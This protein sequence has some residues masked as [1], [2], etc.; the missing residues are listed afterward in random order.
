M[1][2]YAYKYNDI[3][4]DYLVQAEPV[5]GNAA[6][7]RAPSQRPAQA[8][9]KKQQPPVRKH[10]KSKQQVIYENKRKFKIALAKVCI[11]FALFVSMFLMAAVTGAELNT[12]K[13]NLAAAEENYQLCLEQ[14][15]QL[16]LQL[17]NIMQKVDI[18]KIAQEQL[19]LVKVTKDKQL[20]VEIELY[21]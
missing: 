3:F 17:S 5:R 2:Q 21:E 14:N 10:K 19:G 11:I 6:P 7:R 12:A 18:E 8:P 16:K 9:V 20:E 1:A 15:N 13:E 4:D